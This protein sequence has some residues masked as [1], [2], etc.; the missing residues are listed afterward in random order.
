MSVTYKIYLHS[1]LIAQS[2]KELIKSALKKNRRYQSD[3]IFNKIH[4]MY[5]YTS[6]CDYDRLCEDGFNIDMHKNSENIF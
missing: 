6:V 3:A 5:N 1:L 2:H 4:V